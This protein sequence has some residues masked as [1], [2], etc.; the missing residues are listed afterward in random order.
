MGNDNFMNDLREIKDSIQEG[1]KEGIQGGTNF[2]SGKI[3]KINYKEK[4]DVFLSYRRDG[5]E[6]MA[7][8][9]HD[10]LAAKGYKV[11]LDVENLRSGDFNEK[12]LQI[13]ENCTDFVVVLSVGS[14]DRCVNEGD[15][16]RREIA[17]AI[18]HNKNV[19]PLLLRGFEWPEK[20][21]DDIAN[22]PNLGGVNAAT[23]EFFD[24]VIERLTQKF[25]KSKP[26]VRKTKKQ[27]GSHPLRPLK[28]L[29]TS[30]SVITIFAIIAFTVIAMYVL[31]NS[32]GDA[33][34][35]SIIN[36]IIDFFRINPNQ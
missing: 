2:F 9:L 7:I 11:F 5:G 6:T 16:V 13:I 20:L 8:L 36:E 32:D 1:I 25:M 26:K 12:L 15:W 30:I 22:L 23:N 33:T 10:R 31:M 29:I 14:L 24:A 27:K 18:K 35:G 28:W 17:H 19:V 21:P 4:Y 3:G 34:F